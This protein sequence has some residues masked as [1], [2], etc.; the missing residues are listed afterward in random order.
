MAS[1]KQEAIKSLGN[2]N[3]YIGLDALNKERQVANDVYNTTNKSLQDEYNNLLEKI[4]NNRETTKKDFAAGRSTVAENAYQSYNPA[5]SYARGLGTNVSQLNELRQGM[6]VDR[7]NSNLANTF[8][9]TM[10]EIDT[11]ERQGTNKYNIN[12]E[13]ARNTL[14]DTLAGIG[15]REAN[16]RNA[17]NQA[18]ASLA[19]QIQA[20]REAAA[21]AAAALK[22]QKDLAR[23]EALQQFRATLSEK[24]G[25]GDKLTEQT[26]KDAVAYYKAIAKGYGFGTTDEDAQDYLASIGIN[27][28]K[29]SKTNSSNK[30]S[31]TSKR[32]NWLS[33][34]LQSYAN[35]NYGLPDYTDANGNGVY[36]NRNNTNG[37]VSDFRKWMGDRFQV[38]AD[39]WDKMF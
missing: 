27:M 23:Q 19:E 21:Q 29:T 15:T 24:A 5:T 31:S 3:D 36:I 30:L 28:P 22:Q 4:A 37:N 17:Y 7:Q 6:E 13:N 10:N 39:F 38:A 32:N 2:V 8:Y 33:S 26:Y 11:A 18:V 12:L 1:A 20:R 9:N 34:S 16:A 35:K 25:S 14:N